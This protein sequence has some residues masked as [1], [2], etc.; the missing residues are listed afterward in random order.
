[1]NRKK[2]IKVWA[3]VT[4]DDAPIIREEVLRILR[5]YAKHYMSDNELDSDLE[6]GG[7]VESM[8]YTK[9]EWE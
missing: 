2:K 8:G 1:M 4:L 9:E 5:F 6:A 3:Q 7:W